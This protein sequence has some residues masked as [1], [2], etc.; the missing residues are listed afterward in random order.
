MNLSQM[1]N[2]S[3]F[4]MEYTDTYTDSG[5]E[6][7]NSFQEENFVFREYN[8]EGDAIIVSQK[9]KKKYVI[10]SSMIIHVNLEPI[11]N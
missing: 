6:V 10:P 2:G 7:I 3:V 8:S 9:T 5:T 1:A 4:S 11:H